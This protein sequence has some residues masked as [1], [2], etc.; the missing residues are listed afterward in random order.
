MFY[1]INKYLLKL[2]IF[3]F[4]VKYR[5]NNRILMGRKGEDVLGVLRGL[6]IVAEAIF[7]DQNKHCRHVWSNSSVKEALDKQL[8]CNAKYW[9]RVSDEP[10][11]E[12][13]RI[14][15]VVKET[16]ERT[17]VV[18]EGLRQLFLTKVTFS[19]S[20]PSSSTPSSESITTVSS[21]KIGKT[22]QHGLG[23]VNVSSEVDAANLDLSSVTLEELEKFLANR[24]HS[25]HNSMD[26]F[27]L[28]VKTENVPRPQPKLAKPV[29]APSTL[30][31]EYKSSSLTTIAKQRKVPATR[32][33]RMVSF[34]GLFAG[35]GFGTLN[36]LTKGALGLGGSTNIKEAFLN[37]SNAERIVDTLCKVRGA[38][39]KIGQILSIQ[40]S[41][42]VSP[43]LAKAFE[44]VR[45]AADYMPDW[46]VERVLTSE[47]GNNWHLLLEEFDKKP[48]AAASI[49][50][51]HRG[52]LKDGMIVAIKLQY[53]G[54]AQSIE[55][56]I[57]NLIGMLKLW[58]VFP[59]G[60]FIDN[61][62]KVAKREL[63]WE[64]DYER[65][66]QYTEKFKEM[67]ASY[68]CYY[69]PQVIQELTTTKIL[70]TEFVPGI[71][72]DKCFQM[73]LVYFTLDY[74]YC[75]YF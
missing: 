43:E 47:L 18:L 51:V 71:P 22:V 5:E 37:P 23:T 14:R 35:L 70:T 65:E 62:V 74:I 21:Q 33:G 72:L 69:V 36:E 55:S 16:Q 59:Q 40:D 13:K 48:F 45:Q 34:G 29:T 50:Q 2:V 44:R 17:F 57:D 63:K 64:V 10:M 42:V 6:Q 28:S 8:Q 58:N 32:L 54:V 12:V 26:S 52:K 4:L 68:D 27:K 20:S 38:A 75:E 49:G 25:K 1:L 19:S 11:E 30:E 24:R 31:N 73:K 15:Y 3:V 53:P 46:Q 60:F 41:N 56:D 66:A 67:I 9:Q 39:L 7:R 61:V